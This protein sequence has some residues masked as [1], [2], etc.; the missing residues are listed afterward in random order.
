MRDYGAKGDGTSDDTA[1]INS[2][3][4]DGMR[5]GKG[6]NSSTTT[7]ALVYFPA[8]TYVVSKPIVQLYYTQFIGNP[9]DLPTIK[10]SPGFQGMALIDSDPYDDQGNSWYTN[11]NNFYRQIRNFRIDLTG[12][13]ESIGA[14][15]H[16]QVAQATSLQNIVF[17]MKKGGAGNK[18]QGIF[19]DNGSGGFMTDLVF[20]GGAIGAFLG[21]QQFTTRNLTFNDCKT[22]VFMNWNWLWSLKSLHVNNCGVG[23]DMANTPENQTVGSVILADS[24]F[25]NTKIGVNS[26]F[27][28]SSIPR[29]GGT[30][31]LDNVDFSGAPV[32]VSSHTGQ[33]ILAGGRVIDSW[34]QGRQYSGPHGSRI[35]GPLP[36]S[37]KP[38]GLLDST[39]KVFE[40]AK[41]QYA[42]VPASS[43]VSVKGRGAKGDGTTDD[44]RAI[45]E[46]MDNLPKDAILY[47]DHGAYLVSSTVRVPKN[48]RITGEMWPLIMAKGAA[49]QDKEKLTPVFQI[50]QRGDTG[51]VEL[52]DLVFETVGPQPGAL[53]IEFN[54]AGSQPGAAGLWDVHAR[55]GG[56][57]GTDLQQDK[58]SKQPSKRAPADPACMGAGML[59]RITE[60]A[61]AYLENVWAWVADHELDA[62]GNHQINIFNGRGVLIEST[63][64]TWL[65]GTASEH[66]TLYQY[67]VI[68][69][70][71][72]YMSAIQTESP[73]FQSNPGALDPFAPQERLGD[74]SFNHCVGPSCRKSWGLIIEG[75]T[76]VLLYGGGL[77]SFFENWD[78]Q[79]AGD[80]NDCQMN[81]V[82]MDLQPNVRLFGVS[83]KAA[84]NMVAL[85]DG[86][87]IALDRDNRSN[88]CAT[89]ALVEGG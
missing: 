11:Q 69:A 10:G 42:D 27:T 25:V 79:C 13:P 63:K 80:S 58:C 59:I 56:S 54:V 50:G 53:L 35:Q 41:P 51:N 77:Y 24:K 72:L 30:L 16:W 6:C 7:P 40:R 89:V 46:A 84:V 37:K 38:A 61:S 23:V 20:N 39:G 85:G 86:K 68:G 65:Y 36:P 9:A 4:S 29:T 34:A 76:D 70:K 66:S 88:F 22:A 81:M 14:G 82:K 33:T 64:P 74:P 83:T 28:G 5:C 8:G 19:M 17:D 45:Q 55:V 43:F 75:S 31:V 52:S 48:I 3:V 1:A 47:F 21:S 26:S 18:Q 67:A 12:M 57:A 44:T 32:A 73:Y 60:D 15:I 71:N 87:V 2:A 78:Q 49:F 62:Q